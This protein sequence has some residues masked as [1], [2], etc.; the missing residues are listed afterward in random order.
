MAGVLRPWIACQTPLSCCSQTADEPAASWIRAVVQLR[1]A[2][3]ASLPPFLGSSS[4]MQS[5]VL[6]KI[7]AMQALIEEAAMADV[8]QVLGRMPNSP[9][10]SCCSLMG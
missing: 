8:L 10:G 3:P 9:P 4:T 1:T 5:T 2:P 7:L 6:A